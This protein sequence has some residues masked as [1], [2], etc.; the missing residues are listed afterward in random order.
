VER[1]PADLEGLLRALRERVDGIDDGVID[2]E[3][4]EKAS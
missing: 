4:E 1:S 3:L 2:A